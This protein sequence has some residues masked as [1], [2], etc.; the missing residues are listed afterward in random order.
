MPKIVVFG[1]IRLMYLYLR[2]DDSREMTFSGK[3]P[4]FLDVPAGVHRV[5]ATTATK[6][7][8]KTAPRG[9]LLCR[10]KKRQERFRYRALSPKRAPDPAANGSSFCSF[11][12]QEKGGEVLA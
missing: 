7:Q 5:Y 11:F 6:V 4:R 10:V 12:F 9:R 8:R 1:D 3:S 2:V